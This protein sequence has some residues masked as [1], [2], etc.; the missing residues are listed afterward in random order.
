MKFVRTEHCRS[1]DLSSYFS[2]TVSKESLWSVGTKAENFQACNQ[3][4]ELILKKPQLFMC[5]FV[6][7]IH[8]LL[9]LTE[10]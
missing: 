6:Q 9:V 8:I 2:D 1:T 3:V 7:S 5:Q 4:K 10:Q